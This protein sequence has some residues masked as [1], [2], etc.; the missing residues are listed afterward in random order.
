MAF[1]L[2]FDLSFKIKELEST[3]W[4]AHVKSQTAL[5]QIICSNYMYLVPQTGF[6][7]FFFLQ[8]ADI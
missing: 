3:Y 1:I 7:F 2:V 6:R 4:K 8:I 5:L